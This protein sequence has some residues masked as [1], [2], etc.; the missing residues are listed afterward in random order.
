MAVLDFDID[1]KSDSII[2]MTDLTIYEATIVVSKN[3]AVYFP[4]IGSEY[5]TK[6]TTAQAPG[7]TFDLD[8]ATDNK[9]FAGGIYKIIYTIITDSETLTLEKIFFNDK[10]ILECKK[11][12][13]LSLINNS[14]C[15]PCEVQTCNIECQITI[16]QTIMTSIQSEIEQ[17]LYKD[18]EMM[19]AYLDDLCNNC[20]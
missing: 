15:Q 13:I 1:F 20:C 10:F 3:I 9:V 17:T 6:D 8:F 19:Y 2:T 12:K 7:A 5:T 4:K 18:A 11:N 16:M 14:G